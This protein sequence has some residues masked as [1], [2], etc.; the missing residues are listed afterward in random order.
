MPEGL[1]VTVP[2]PVPLMARAN[3]GEVLKLAVTEVF[4]IN[5]TLQTAVPLQAPDHPPKNEF[6]AGDAVSV[7]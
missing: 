1:L 2:W 5:V 7:T 4:C 3:T 6:V